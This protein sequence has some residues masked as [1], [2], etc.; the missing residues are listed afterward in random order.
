MSLKAAL[1]EI[2]EQ[3]K[4][5]LERENSETPQEEVVEPVTNEPKEEETPE[6]AAPEEA[7][8]EPEKKEEEKEPEKPAVL[9]DSAYARMRREARAAEKRALEA[10][11]RLAQELSKKSAEISA[12]QA[13]PSAQVPD[14]L[15]E[16]VEER[17]FKRAAI[18]LERIEGEFRRSVPDYDAVANQYANAVAQSIRIQNP[19]LTPK[20]IAEK[21]E[22]TI[23][24]KAASFSSQGFNPVEEMYYEA[25]ELGFG[26]QSTPP[27]STEEP[28]PVL[29]PDMK[30]GAA[31]RA[32]SSGMAAVGGKSE[33]Q[34]TQ[35]AADNL[36]VAEWAKLPV[37]TRERLMRGE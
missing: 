37:E 6:E 13:A 10:E 11:T 3:L 27:K 17:Q 28:A 4:E 19:R 21:A 24:L 30:K 25:K 31:N 5:A 1:K 36:T 23:L 33:G 12:E 16:V 14:E 8:K 18:E 32:R 7:P 20:E 34:L 29:R 26:A 2:D 35:S 22:R 9:D 15:L